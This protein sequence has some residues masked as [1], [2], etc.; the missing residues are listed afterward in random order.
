[1]PFIFLKDLIVY[2]SWSANDQKYPFMSR[3]V[4]DQVKNTLVEVQ[5]FHKAAWRMVVNEV[6]AE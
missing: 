6:L 2:L 5:N 3:A 4:P 1:M